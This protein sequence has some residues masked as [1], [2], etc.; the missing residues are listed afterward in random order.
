[1]SGTTLNAA[2]A[3][4]V[5]DGDKQDITVLASGTVWTIDPA[6]VTYT[7]LQ[8]TTA[9]AI[10]LGRGAGAGAALCRKLRSGRT[11]L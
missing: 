11:S 9:S 6:T 2:G 3:S 8:N 7:K 10:L 4:G 1:M 5:A